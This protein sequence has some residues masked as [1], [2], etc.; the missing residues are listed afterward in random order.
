MADM[1]QA[2]YKAKDVESKVGVVIRV[3]ITKEV[4]A[5][6]TMSTFEGLASEYQDFAVADYTNEMT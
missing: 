4:L 2:I 1:I 6:L 5:Q 3:A